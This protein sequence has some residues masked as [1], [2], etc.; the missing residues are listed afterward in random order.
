MRCKKCH[1]DLPEN[2][3]YCPL[4]GKK[5]VTGQRKTLR[6][7]NGLGTVYRLQG[8]RN[9]PWVAAKNRVIIGYYERK[10]DALEA[11]ERLSGRSITERYNM[12]FED[13]YLAWKEEHF[14]E[15][16]PSGVESYENAFRVFAPLHDQKFR[17]LKTGDFQAIMDT[18]IQAGKAYS[19]LSKY[20]QLLTQMS[21]W[22][23][24]EEIITTSF[25]RFVRLPENEKKEKEIFTEEDIRK[26]EADGSETARIILML[27]YT[28]MR[29]GE[30]FSLPLADYHETYVVG[31]EKT[32]AGRNRI[33]P[34]RPE[35][36]K[37]FAYFASYAEGE[38]LLSGYTG[39]K[40]VNNFRRRDY[41]PL[42]E[43][44]GIERKTPHATRHTYASR[45]RRDGMPP[46][47][48]QKILGHASYTTTANIYVHTNIE[49]LLAA[50]E[51]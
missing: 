31:G 4:C 18:Q 7:A 41:Y 17:S 23:M 39:Q 2:A 24:R 10:T 16:G 33:I 25:A 6:R 34:I 19:T 12:T 32:E 27:I 38:L 21:N 29:I 26:L 48:L 30:L 43:K 14:R 50:V 3:V 51:K 13:V 35:G 49:E 37:H 20:K 8:R 15:I 42:L 22:A 9:R 1:A 47:I 28:G 46:E 44:L 36:R 5:Q 11:L 45:A 40:L